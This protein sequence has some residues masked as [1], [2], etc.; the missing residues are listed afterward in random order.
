MCKL[1][2]FVK[3]NRERK[4]LGKLGASRQNNKEALR[5]WHMKDNLKHYNTLRVQ[6][7]SNNDNNS[8]ATS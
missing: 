7:T 1:A 5:I 4:S 2:G 8:A 3:D 6:N